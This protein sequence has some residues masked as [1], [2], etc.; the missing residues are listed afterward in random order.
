M[1]AAVLHNFGE[2]PRYENFTDPIPAKDEKIIYVKAVALEN[3]I[4][5]M[6]NGTHYSSKQFFPKFP[7]IVGLGGIGMTDDGKLVSFRGMKPPYGALAEKV[8]ASYAIPIPDGIDAAV[9]AA[10][11]SSI[12]TSLL[13]LKYTTKL[14]EGETVLINGATGVSGKI[15]VQVAKMLGAERVIA[16]GRNEATLKSLNNLGAD[17]VINL[18]QSDKTLLE[19]FTKEAGDKGFNIVIDFLW[20]HPAEILMKSFIPK[21]IGFAKKRIRYVHVGEKAGSTISLSGEMLRTSGLEIYGAANITAE[22]VQ[23]EMTQVWDWIKQ[24]KLQIDIEKIPLSEIENVWDHNDLAGKRL[25][26]V[27]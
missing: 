3:V 15:A 4:K 20:G 14:Q 23:Q 21:E 8:V 13:P 9:A 2:I 11:P 18:Q 22:S 17:A 7:A 27:P 12:L 26:I 6:A 25:V 24:N 10:L 1:K 16:T 19:S 5:M